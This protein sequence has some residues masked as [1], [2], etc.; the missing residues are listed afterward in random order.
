[1]TIVTNE[2]IYTALGGR[3][4]TTEERFLVIPMRDSQSDPTRQ[5]QRETVNQGQR[6][7]EQTIELQRNMAQMAV[8]A[9]EWQETAQT[10]GLQF[11][12]S[13]FQNYVEGVEAVLPKMQ[14]AMEEGT[15]SMSEGRD[16]S[17]MQRQGREPSLPPDQQTGQWTQRQQLYGQS[18][19]Q[20]PQSMHDQ[21]PLQSNPWQSQTERSQQPQQPPQESGYTQGRSDDHR[22][23]PQSRSGPQSHR[24]QG[25]RSP[26]HRSGEMSARHEQRQGQRTGGHRQS[27]TQ[28]QHEQESHAESAPRSRGD[29]DSGQSSETDDASKSGD[30][31][32]SS[33]SS[34][35]EGSKSTTSSKSD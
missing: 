4:V 35:D 8:S 9:L 25:E 20:R 22:S 13:M 29:A 33:E 34:S 23:Q 10:Q 12:R 1:M 14:A 19:E 11:T 3:L 5:M 28:P 21:E 31:S 6:A 7:L 2:P 30:S 27:T 24:P 17:M 18:P 32:K 15:R 26:S 16:S